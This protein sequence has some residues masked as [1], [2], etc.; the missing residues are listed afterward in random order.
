MKGK[1]LTIAGSDPSGGAGVQADIK[2]IGALGGY[3]MAVL[4]ALTSQNTQE[5]RDVHAIP[6]AFVK[7]QIMMVCDDIKPDV[8]KTGMLWNQEIMQEVVEAIEE[9]ASDVPLILDPVAVATSG[10]VLLQED[11]VSYLK[12]VLVPK[13]SMITPNL[14]EAALLSAVSAEEEGF[15]QR[16]GEE[17]LSL[18]AEYVLIKGGHA[19]YENDEIENWLFSNIEEPQCFR[20]KRVKSTNTHGTGCTMASAIA[21][22]IAQGYD[23]AEAV[24]RSQ[25]YVAGAI[26]HAPNLGSGNGP[27]NHYWQTH[28]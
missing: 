10:S 23:V 16:A 12:Q 4:T 15:I 8:I 28:P 14:D 27:L 21:T 9:S 17:L 22:F 24:Q 26:Q 20:H 6:A 19:E 2:T 13:S 5:V 1:V 7:E 25:A 18:D 11:A 3:A